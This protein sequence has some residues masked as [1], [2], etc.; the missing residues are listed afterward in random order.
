MCV[1]VRASVLGL[2][3]VCAVCSKGTLCVVCREPWKPSDTNM[4]LCDHCLEWVHNECDAATRGIKDGDEFQCYVCRKGRRAAIG[5]AVGNAVSRVVAVRLDLKSRWRRLALPRFV[6]AYTSHHVAGIQWYPCIIALAR[7]RMQVLAK[8]LRRYTIPTATAATVPE[9]DTPQ[10]L[11]RVLAESPGD[12]AH[13]F[14]SS[15][16]NVPFQVRSKALRFV[17]LQLCASPVAF[18]QSAHGYTPWQVPEFPSDGLSALQ[19]GRNPM[20]LSVSLAQYPLSLVSQAVN[21][22]AFLYVLSQT[23][24]ASNFIQ[25]YATTSKQPVE[26]TCAVLLNVRALC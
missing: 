7:R 16:V 22:S 24:P 23:K 15:V 10:T 20:P 13:F 5:D 8:F 17:R 6:D 2:C 3:S 11:R 19:Q 4:T 1:C 14:M 9:A 25:S 12:F 21:A 18:A 26:S